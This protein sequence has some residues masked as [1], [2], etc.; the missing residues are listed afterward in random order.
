[1]EFSKP[2]KY[3]T[4]CSAKEQVSSKVYIARFQLEKPNE[5]AFY[6]GQTM[7]L[8]VAP[9]INRAMTI[10]SPPQDTHELTIY[11][12]ISPG[13]P[14]SQ[15]MQALKVGDP[16]EFMAP[17]G[18]FVLDHESPRRRVFVATGTGIAPFRAMLF[19][20]TFDWRAKETNL[21]WGLR[22]EEDVFLNNAF[23]IFDEQEPNFKFYFVL[24][25]PSVNWKGLSGHVTDHVLANEKEVKETDFY[26]CGGRS[27]LTEMK[28]KLLALGVSETQIK[29]DPFY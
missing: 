3:V 18:R 27:M 15:W 14:G 6:A 5:V 29:F 12:D 22:Y 23:K 9:G 20:T 17:L 19:D 8:Y 7:M 2:Q 1:M 28:D 24:S 25:K 21:Y 16:V 13:G 26:L 10:A 11:Q 4:I